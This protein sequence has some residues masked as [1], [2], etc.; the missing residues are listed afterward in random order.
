MGLRAFE[1]A[2]IDLKTSGFNV[3]VNSVHQWCD[4]NRLSEYDA[5]ELAV[6]LWAM[7]HG[8]ACLSMNHQLEKFLPDV[9]VCSLL[10]SSTHTFLEGLK[11]PA[12]A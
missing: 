4:I 2:D 10:E 9:D 5:Q 11:H 1:A 8:L 12:D 6:K 7:A 3:L